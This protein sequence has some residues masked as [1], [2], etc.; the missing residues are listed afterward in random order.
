MS[1]FLDLKIKNFSL[2]INEL[3][4]KVVKVKTGKKSFFVESFNEQE[5][6]PGTIKDGI[7]QDEDALVEAIKQVCK[8]VK[9]D[10]LKTNCV[11]V[12]LPE[13]QSFLTIMQMPLMKE[14]E[15]ET[16]VPFEAE[17]YI[18]MPVED[19]YMDFQ[20]IPFLGAKQDHYD[21]LLVAFPKNVI[22]KYLLCLKKAGLNVL[23]MEVESQSMARSLIKNQVSPFPVLIVDFGKS[24]TNFAIYSGSSLRFTSSEEIC[25]RMID[26]SVSKSLKISLEEAESLKIKYGMEKEKEEKKGKEAEIRKEV[27]KASS[28]TAFALV[29]EI[30]KYL[31]Y[32]EGHQNNDRKQAK[33]KKGVE[34]IILCGGGANLKVLD[35]FIS[36]ALNIPVEFGDPWVN[37]IKDQKAKA[38]AISRGESLGYAAALGLALRGI[39]ENST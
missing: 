38:P 7:I 9:G 20:V 23:A 18:P 34:K 11:M 39:K 31:Y 27:F 17:N 15:L 19:V 25:S 16:A 26:E 21:I 5:L 36:S 1:D 22:D 32:Y 4:L 6:K 10:R 29:E 2:G 24:N 30:K 14:K 37:I 8:N 13:E 3:S 35:A 12:S 33:G 28:S